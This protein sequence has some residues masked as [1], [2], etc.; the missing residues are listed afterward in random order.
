MKLGTHAPNSP[1]AQITLPAGGAVGEACRKAKATL[2]DLY[3]KRLYYNTVHS[4]PV[5]A[6]LDP[7][8]LL[9]FASPGTTCPAL[10]G[11]VFHLL[12]SLLPR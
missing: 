5:V 6:E 1:P 3:F 12:L 10:L 2:L 4:L 7:S 11:V 8:I 9:G